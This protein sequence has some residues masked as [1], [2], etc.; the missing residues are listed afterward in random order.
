M[1]QTHHGRRSAWSPWGWLALPL[2]TAGCGGGGGG[3]LTSTPPTVTPSPS[4]SPPQPV[5]PF[6]G[7]PPASFFLTDEVT[8]TAAVR[9]ERGNGTA[10]VT[11]VERLT[12]VLAPNRSHV[13]VEYRGPDSYA[14]EM[15][16]FGGPSFLPVE[17]EDSS[18]IFDTYRSQDKGGYV[19][20]LQ[21]AKKGAGI[22]LTYMSFGSYGFLNISGASSELALSFLAIGS[23]TP[24]SQMPTTGSARFSGIVDGLWVDGATTRRLYGSTATLTADFAAG[25]VTSVLALTGRDNP[26]GD[27]QSAPATSLG[28]FTGT[29]TIDASGF[30]G[31]YGASNGYS[32]PFSGHFYGPAA[33]EHGLTFRLSGGADKTV[34]GVAVGKRD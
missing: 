24:A 19:D 11:G 18:P 31:N 7:T 30:A 33:E 22:T 28:T 21:V 26:F 2:L 3:D 1:A 4:P 34:F 20:I 27:F 32:G 9:V 5:P 25:R 23:R 17:R 13:S 29:G 10:R 14:I 8:A 16:G 6:P 15:N 12:D